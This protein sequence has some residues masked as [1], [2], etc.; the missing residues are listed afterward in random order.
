MAF[1]R[2]KLILHVAKQTLI[3]IPHLFCSLNHVGFVLASSS[4]RAAVTSNASI[5]V[6]YSS[7]VT[8]IVRSMNDIV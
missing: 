7:S 2:T 3:G 8:A 4:Y 6:V 5:I 1:S